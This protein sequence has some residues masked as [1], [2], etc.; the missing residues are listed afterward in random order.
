MPTAHHRSAG[1]GSAVKISVPI[2]R[3]DW[4]KTRAAAAVL[5]CSERTLRRRLEQG[6]WIEGVHWRRVTARKRSIIEINLPAVVR[7]MN[8]R[9]WV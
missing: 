1:A 7:L 9:G 2:A 6:H 8:A 3:R 4:F 5:G